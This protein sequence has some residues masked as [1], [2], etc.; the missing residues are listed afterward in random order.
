VL[1]Y[2]FLQYVDSKSWFA[3]IKNS[4]FNSILILA[5]TLFNGYTNGS[6]SVK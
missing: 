6:Q 3:L 4:L 5:Q 2:F 1:Y